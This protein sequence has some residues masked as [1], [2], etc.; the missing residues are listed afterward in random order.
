M[1]HTAYCWRLLTLPR[2]SVNVRMLQ[3]ASDTLRF[4][5]LPQLSLSSYSSFSIL[6]LPVS[7]IRLKGWYQIYEDWNGLNWATAPTPPNLHHLFIVYCF[8]DAISLAILLNWW[9]SIVWWLFSQ[10]PPAC[11]LFPWNL[12]YMSEIGFIW[13][14]H[15]F[16]F[17]IDY[18]ITSCPSLC[19]V[20]HYDMF[21]PAWA[22]FCFH[23]RP[24][25]L[26]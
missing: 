26:C 16:D 7:T 24:C 19:L 17:L 23:M 10:W 11:L 4:S 18:Q 8:S 5:T 22:L 9:K 12:E 14:S 1:T 20:S 3:E 15:S 21:S 2:S 6:L 25:Y 13:T